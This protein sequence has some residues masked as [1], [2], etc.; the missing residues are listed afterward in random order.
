MISVP[1]NSVQ[2][3]RYLDLFCIY[4]L[5]SLLFLIVIFLKIGDMSVLQVQYC[6]QSV[7]DG[8]PVFDLGDRGYIVPNSAGLVF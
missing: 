2:M 1:L 7:L 5:I 8:S 6:I 4:K 3:L